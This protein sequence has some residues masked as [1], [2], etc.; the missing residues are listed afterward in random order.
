MLVAHRKGTDVAEEMALLDA[1]ARAK[2][3]ERDELLIKLSAM[4]EAGELA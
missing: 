3:D 4:A 2:G 1:V